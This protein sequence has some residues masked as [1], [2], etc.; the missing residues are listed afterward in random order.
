MIPTTWGDILSNKKGI[1]FAKRELDI[2]EQEETENK[3]KKAKIE[4]DLNKFLNKADQIQSELESAKNN[5]TQRSKS[6]ILF[7][8][9][10]KDIANLSYQA[11]GL[12]NDSLPYARK[13]S[14]LEG[15]LKVS[16]SLRYNV[17]WMEMISIFSTKTLTIKTSILLTLNGKHS[18]KFLDCRAR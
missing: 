4:Q 5:L 9:V 14:F 16:L 11:Q 8:T 2:L 17:Q 1:E 18:T 7:S 12:N 6:D 10:M 15:Y 13:Q 3:K